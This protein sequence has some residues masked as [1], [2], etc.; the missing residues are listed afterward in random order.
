MDWLALRTRP[1]YKEMR[2]AVEHSI[3]NYWLVSCNGNYNDLISSC[4]EIT[5]TSFRLLK[6]IRREIGGLIHT[7]DPDKVTN[8]VSD[9]TTGFYCLGEGS[10]TSFQEESDVLEILSRCAYGEMKITKQAKEVLESGEG[11]V[12]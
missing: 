7:I 5:L 4:D 11:E 8:D 3:E 12:T 1:I 6:Y 10:T 9:A 2:L